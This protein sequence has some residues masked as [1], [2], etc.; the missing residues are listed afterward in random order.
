MNY[1]SRL[2]N[3]RGGSS[4]CAFAYSF[5]APHH[6]KG[7]WDGAGGCMKHKVDQDT[8]SAMT[9][10]TLPYTSSGYIETVTD[11]YQSLVHH[12]EK[13][14]HRDRRSRG[15]SFHAW[16]F[17]LYTN[18]TDPVPR[19]TE[20]ITAMKCISENYQFIVRQEG[21]FYKRRRVCYCLHCIAAMRLGFTEWNGDEFAIPNCVMASLGCDT[22]S[23]IY[24]FDRSHCEQTHGPNVSQQLQQVIRDITEMA[25]GL[26]IGDWVLFDSRMEDEPIWLGRV[27]SNPEWEGMGVNHNT[28]RRKQTYDNGV[29]I[30]GNEV[31]I[32]VQWYEKIDI[33]SRGLNYRASRSISDP[34]I[35]SNFYLIYAG[36]VM[37]EMSG[38]VNLVPKLRSV[39][40]RQNNWHSKEIRFKWKMDD[41]V[42][43]AALSKCGLN[44]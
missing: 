32:F 30:S 29:E 38:G 9:M 36:F 10:G 39:A 22:A 2:I 11:V 26:N 16:R 3:E 41:C 42:R 21:L 23:N 44:S 14:D 19:P 35:Q 33:N 12:F 18:A 40:R 31:A 13:G 5:G 20:S 43:D 17:F 6:G 24:T 28:T 1:Y 27:M 15:N 37:H 4:K 7:K 8:S 34:Q 25:I